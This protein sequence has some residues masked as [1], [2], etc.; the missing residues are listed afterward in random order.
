MTESLYD[1][2]KAK[3][4]F[5]KVFQNYQ[6]IYEAWDDEDILKQKMDDFQDRL[7][8]MNNNCD[9]M[10]EYINDINKMLDQIQNIQDK[11]E[12]KDKNESDI[13]DTSKKSSLV[14]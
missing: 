14:N 9:Q 13:I 4:A 1:K 10:R 5:K 7:S 6:N 12:K 8:T 2:I 3:R 11:S